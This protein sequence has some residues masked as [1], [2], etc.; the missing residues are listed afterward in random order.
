[1]S[2]LANNAIQDPLLA[3]LYDGMQTRLLVSVRTA[4]EALSALA[5]GA[6]V[7]DVKEPSR[8]SLGRADTDT[9]TDVVLAVNSRVPVTAALGELLEFDP[10]S[11][12]P[13]PRGI[14]LSKIG[15]SGCRTLSDWPARWQQAISS[16]AGGALSTCNGTAAVAYADWAAAN[17]P[18]PHRVLQ[19]AVE[20]GCCALLID[21]WNK[22]N[23][24]LFDHW[25]ACELKAFVQLARS[26]RLIV[27]L[28][29][30]L[31]GEDI[32]RAAQI[33]PNVIAVRTAA[34]DGGRNG[35]VNQERVRSI[36]ATIARVSVSGIAAVSELQNS[37]SSD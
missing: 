6:D 30:S 9:L 36:K 14:T 18:E 22:W 20:L 5:G 12:S 13:I 15:L 21:T 27:A 24:T 2:P 34:C 7:I 16:Y 33:K 17:A 3:V 35:A 10:A 25:P 31:V 29:G 1:M 28:A 8:G 11:A 37:L 19:T 4:C 32:V 23:G 26:Q